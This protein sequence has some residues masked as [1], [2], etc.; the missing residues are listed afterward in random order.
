MFYKEHFIRNDFRT[1]QI[2]ERF[3][4]RTSNFL[5]IQ[6]TQYSREEY[7]KERVTTHKSEIIEGT[8]NFHTFGISLLYL[9]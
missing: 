8:L 6:G 5:E 2:F 4:E 7:L 1:S 3:K 9:M